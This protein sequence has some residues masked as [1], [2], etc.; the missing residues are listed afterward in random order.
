MTR[1]ED[2]LSHALRSTA[3]AA[4]YDPTSVSSVAARA[5]RIRRR[6]RSRAVLTAAAAVGVI[7][8]PGAIL[9][10]PDAAPAP[11][12]PSP[13][14]SQPTA[15]TSPSSPTTSLSARVFDIDDLPLGA[16]PRLGYAVEGEYVAAD[17]TR[18]PAPPAGGPLGQFARVG[19]GFLYTET[20]YGMSDEGVPTS[21]STYRQ[22]ADGETERLGCSSGLHAGN[23]GAVGYLAAPC[24]GAGDGAAPQ[25]VVVVSSGESTTRPVPATRGRPELV[26]LRGDDVIVRD[27]ETRQLWAVPPSGQ[28]R[29]IDALTAWRPRGSEIVS[30]SPDGR[31][32]LLQGID[33]PGN[34]IADAA[35]GEILGTV[36]LT[37]FS[38]LPGLSD[39]R[40]EDEE[41]LLGLYPEFPGDDVVLLRVDVSGALEAV[42]RRLPADVRLED[43]TPPDR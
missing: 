28:P 32:V 9:L 33:A 22:G 18:R 17:G 35:T 8:L 34:T 14:T 42:E 20:T 6:H 24:P 23:G 5:R 39:L 26:L 38:G 43:A 40:W 21:V 15:T 41:H 27:S 30:F 2:R 29:R 12:Q 13:T 10:R 25:L 36:P 37:E 16:P 1:S 7:A 4:A 3:D 11:A 31:H 19:D